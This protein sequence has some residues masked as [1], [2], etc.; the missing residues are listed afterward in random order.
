[1]NDENVKQMIAEI[2]QVQA[3][4]T[5]LVIAAVAKQ[6]DANRLA[7]DVQQ[8][9]YVGTRLQKVS[10]LV[11]RQTKLL[12]AAVD[13]EIQQRKMDADPTTH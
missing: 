11:A 4:A 9:L 13:A 3:E 2:L 7:A 5:A 12:L 6:L 10:P 8:F 1:M